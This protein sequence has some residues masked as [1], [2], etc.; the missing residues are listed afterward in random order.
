MHHETSPTIWLAFI[1]FILCVLALDLGVF[2]KK[3]HAVGFKESIIWSLVWIAISMLFSGIIYLWHGHDD[4]MKFLTGYVIEKCLSLDNLFVF[5]LIFD[6]FKIPSQF[7]HKVLFYGILGAL[8]MRA[9]F[10]WAGISILS[11]FA[12]VIYVFGAFLVYSGIKMIMPQKEVVD[13]EKSWVMNWIKKV[14]PT[15]PIMKDDKFFLR[16]N[17]VL[18]I[19]PLLITLIFVEVS[20]IVFA[21]DSIPAIIGISHDPFLVFT[22]NVFAILGLR[23][24]YFSLKGFADLFVYLKYGL[25]LI[26]IFIGGKMLVSGFYHMPINITMI[27]IFSVLGMSILASVM[28]GH[29]QSK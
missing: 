4:S 23:S 25:S 22:S 19:T 8:V 20:D 21:I 16:V 1:I 29:F 12:W 11:E 6:Y 17:G 10:I 5:L 18:T 2:H 24:L 27:V 14:I 7:Q 3:S 13:L 26:L 9:L 15:T 28:R